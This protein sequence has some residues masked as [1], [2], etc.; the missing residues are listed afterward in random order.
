MGQDEAT[1]LASIRDQAD[2]ALATRVL[3]DSIAAIENFE[4]TDDE[5]S[6]HVMSMFEGSVEDPAL[7]GQCSCLGRPSRGTP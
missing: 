6:E 4:V 1:F 5:I 7:C 2:H 3:L